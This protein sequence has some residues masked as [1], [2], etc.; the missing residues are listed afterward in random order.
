MKIVVT[1]GFTLNP[2]DLTWNNISCLGELVLYDRTP[3]EFIIERCSDADVILTNKVPLTKDVLQS[4]PALKL[5][6]VLATGYNVIDIVAAKQ[7]GVVVC[8]A[9]AYG[10]ASVAQHVFALLLE[11]TN[12]VGNN[13]RATASGM[14]QQSIDWCFTEAPLME[15]HGKTMGIAGFGNIGQQTARIAIAFGMNIIYYNPSNK[16]TNLGTP[17]DMQTLFKQSDVVSLHCSLNAGNMEFVNR[18]LL[19]T[20]KPSAIIINTAR[21]Q[22]INERDLADA[23]NNN[24]LGGAALDVLSKE[25]PLDDNPL[26]HAKNC[27][28]TPHTAWMSKEARQRIMDIT[29]ANIKAF[30]N[31]QP[32]N[33]VN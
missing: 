3:T 2:G 32:I 8:N 13:S 20:M 24:M 22:L 17:V 14:W 12:H 28:I 29:A 1:D 6:S 10:I 5:I 15:L 21:G 25:P 9:P 19:Q 27:I 23:L 31:N 33:T 11:L 30:I 4:L 7:H 18:A 26:L 16:P